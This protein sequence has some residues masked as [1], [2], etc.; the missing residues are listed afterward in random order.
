MR[1]SRSHARCAPKSASDG[2]NKAVE[3]AIFQCLNIAIGSIEPRP[4]RLPDCGVPQRA[5]MRGRKRDRL[6][7]EAHC[8][9]RIGRIPL[10][11]A[12]IAEPLLI[13]AVISG[14]I[15]PPGSASRPATIA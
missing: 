14:V 10:R 8:Y 1:D 3:R 2:I 5:M 11:L 6:L 9:R 4:K 15:K 12:S 7:N 13:S